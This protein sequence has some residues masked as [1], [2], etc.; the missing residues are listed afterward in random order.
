MFLAEKMHGLGKEKS[1]IREIFEYGIKRKNE[2][3]AENV[4]DFSLGNPSVPTSESVTNIL[5]QLIEE[6]PPEKL[7]A[8]TSGS[9]ALSVRQSIADYIQSTFGCEAT[10]SHIYITCGAAASLTISFHALL[11]EGDEVLAIAPFFPEYKVFVEKAGGKLVIVQAE[12]GTFQPNLEAIEN[13]IN[14][15]TKVLI[16]NTPNNPTGVV[17]P[18]NI[19]QSI[20][21]LL[22]KKQKEYGHPI[23]IISDEPYRELVYDG[24]VPYIPNYYANT[25]VNYSFSKSL[26]LAGERIGYIFVS[27]KAEQSEEICFAVS[28]AGRSLGFVCAPSLFQYVIEKNLGQHVDVSIYKRNRD[29]LYDYL[30]NVGFTVVHPDGAFYLFLKA[31]IVD[32]KEFCEK[33]KEY[34][35]LLVPSDSFG[36]EGY[37]RISYCVEEEVIVNSLP[38]FAELAKHYFQA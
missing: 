21:D 17:Y 22:E 34:E 18:E 38:A 25:I 28:G 6:V 13:S 24:E 35:L 4:F 33:A 15:R 1:V 23:F 32:A 20:A 12:E 2:I 19:I 7:H 9:G 30:T 29:L 26:S 8:Y 27:P 10:A 14:E 36:Y 5:M 11:K 37:V 31:P 3:G 16:L